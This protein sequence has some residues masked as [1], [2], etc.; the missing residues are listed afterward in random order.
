MKLLLLASLGLFM[1]FVDLT[2]VNVAFPDIA[3]EFP[4]ASISGLSWVLS[5]YGIVSAAF[6]VPFGRLADVVGR[7]RV[8]VSALAAFTATSAL[9]AAAPSAEALIGARVLQGLS[10]AAL[11]PTGFALVMAAFGP[12]RRL[13]AVSIS[14][15]VGA[16]AGG[17]GP[18]LGG[19]LIAAADWRLV[20][21]VNVPVGVAAVVACVR[22]LPES[23]DERRSA[24]PDV[25]GALLCALAVGALALAI[26]QGGEWG[27]SDGRVLGALAAA[28]LFGAALAWRCGHHPDPLIDPELIRVRGFTVAT[29]AHAT[30][31]AGFFGYTLCNVIFLTSIWDYSLLE[32]GGALT[33]G[34]I[35]AF[36]VAAGSSRLLQRIDA[37]SLL[38]PGGLLWAG[39]VCWLA[40]RADAQPDFLGLWL[41]TVVV[42]GIGAG[43]VVS[44]GASA[45]INAAPGD[46]FATACGLQQVGRA[47]GA[48]LG[49]AGA[50]AIVGTPSVD[51]AQDAW[52]FG[53]ACLA[54]GAIGSLGIVGARH[55]PP[56]L[57]TE[58]SA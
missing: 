53:A 12:E 51:A 43:L 17:I 28:L 9:C 10:A 24:R 46:R 40:L 49:V 18:A 14:A 13:E 15:A 47:L 48:A 19:L 23:R 45:A 57:A 36:V 54:A 3:R 8:Y 7:K 50:A 11:V 5:G 25:A 44:H 39:A 56:V 35:V 1:A 58:A 31:M 4:D 55:A 33:P 29:L 6:L 37:R 2:I 41:P 21:L 22:A 34:P 20:F 42:A 30:S 38:V 26:T 52:L 32:A 16:L 27:W